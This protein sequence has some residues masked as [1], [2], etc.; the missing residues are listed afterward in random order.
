[1]ES[2]ILGT[3]RV[4]SYKTWSTVGDAAYPVGESPCGYAVFDET[5]HAFVMLARNLKFRGKANDEARLAVANSFAAYCG[6]FTLNRSEATISIAVE[7]SNV[8]SQVGTMQDRPYQI[9]GD[10]LLLSV[11]GQYRAT[12]QRVSKVARQPT[13]Q[14]QA[15]H[16]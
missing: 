9:D 7:A 6:T 10:I 1:M 11:P 13:Q 3:W 16:A 5:G 4:L 8:A 14:L 15:A 2:S 12:L